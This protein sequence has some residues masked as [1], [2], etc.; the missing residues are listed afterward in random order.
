M[1]PLFPTSSGR[2]ARRHLGTAAIAVTTFLTFLAMTAL[3]ARAANVVTPGDFT[4][5][6]FD[7]CTAPTQA[8][9]DAWL[10]GSPYWAV[11]IYISGDS[12]G[13]RSQPNLT[14][15][16]VSTQ[17][18]K[19]WRLL[20]ITLGPQA[21]CTTVPRYLSQ[22]RIK[23]APASSYAAARSQGRAEADKTVGVAQQL[24]IVAGSTLWYDIESFVA[25]STDCRESAL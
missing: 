18:A 10:T 4:G 17:L 3:P 23:P 7:Q 14:P 24:G 21:S 19:G 25:T 9:M 12:R 1:S 20:P 16:W 6:G 11:G 5:Y 2:T 13:C 22:V 8:A 15:T